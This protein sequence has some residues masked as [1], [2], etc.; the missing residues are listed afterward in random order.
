MPREANE[1]LIVIGD[2]EP[3][4]WVLSQGKMAFSAERARTARLE[5]GDSVFIYATR[6]CFRNPTMGRSRVIGEAKVLS[7]VGPLEDPVTF[8]EQT[9]TVGCDLKIATLAPV[10]TGVDF[11]QL[12]PMMHA[13]PVHERWAVYLRRPLVPL[14][15]HDAELLR[16][17]LQPAAK[18]P[19]ATLGGYLQEARKSPSFSW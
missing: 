2:R 9:Y 7:D 3:L 18:R 17:N 11:A 16:R 15:K 19:S 5:R 8:G 6:G 12:A 4:A 14:D 10:K 13:F 1:Y